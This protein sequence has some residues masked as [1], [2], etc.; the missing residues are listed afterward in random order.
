MA[1]QR[2]SALQTNKRAVPAV[3]STASRRTKLNINLCIETPF[4]DCEFVHESISDT[5]KPEQTAAACGGV[6]SIYVHWKIVS[7]NKGKHHTIDI[8]YLI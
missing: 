1:E 8:I 3:H 6:H 7:D 2:L 5:R 4:R